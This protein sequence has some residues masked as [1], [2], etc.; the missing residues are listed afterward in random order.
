MIVWNSRKRK[1]VW[2][3]NC[4]AWESN[5][6]L[7]K[8]TAVVSIL[9]LVGGKQSSRRPHLSLQQ[10]SAL[11]PTLDIYKLFFCSTKTNLTSGIQKKRHERLSNCSKDSDLSGHKYRLVSNL[12]TLWEPYSYQCHWYRSRHVGST[13]PNVALKGW[14]SGRTC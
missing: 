10:S 2:N 13:L 11:M 14:G 12:E 6:K 8:N 4:A 1:R 9:W 5:R 3:V 7:S